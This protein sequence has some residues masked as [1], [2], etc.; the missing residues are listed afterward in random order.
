MDEPITAM[1]TEECWAFLGHQ[2]LGR[3]AYHLLE[4]VHIV[5]VNY[6]VEHDPDADRRTLLFRTAEGSKL[7]GMIMNADVAFEA[8]ELD[9]DTATSVI[10]R[11]RARVLDE[12][13]EHRAEDLP[14]RPWVP[15]LKYNVVELEVAEISGRRF[16]LSRPW[17]HMIPE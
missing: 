9:E 15:T 11:G 10:L 3:L 1:S 4:E 5:P 7:I 2:E 14:L 16:E 13:E 6:A 12:H 17:R 8:D